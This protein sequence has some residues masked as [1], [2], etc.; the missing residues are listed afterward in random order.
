[1]EPYYDILGIEQTATAADVEAAYTRL[2]VFYDRADKLESP[3]YA[4]I[5][6]AYNTVKDSQPQYPEDYII[7]RALWTWI[8]CKDR[9][10]EWNTL[11]RKSHIQIARKAVPW[12]SEEGKA[13]KRRK[14]VDRKKGRFRGG[15]NDDE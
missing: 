8:T 5:E 6:T 10:G 13:G 15:A 3:E 14:E 2:N 4:D 7:D 1:M 12:D 11:V 9:D